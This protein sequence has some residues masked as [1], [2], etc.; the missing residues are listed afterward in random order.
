MMLTRR[1]LYV[2]AVNWL[3]AA[4][5]PAQAPVSL[6][7]DTTSRGHAIPDDFSGLSF[8]RGTENSGNAGVPGYLFSPSNTQLVT[9][10]QNLG[11]RNLRVGGGSVDDEIPVGTGSDGYAGVD[12]LFQF[13]QAA[14]VKVIYSLRLLNPSAQ[15][16]PNL[17]ADNA[18]LAQHIWSSYQSNLENFSI[19]NEP[20]FHSYHT[21]DPLI[22]ETIPGV[23]GSAYP[24][25]L[26][27]W[28][29]FANTVL[30]SVPGAIFS[31]PDTGA[32][33]TLTYTPDASTGVSWTQ[34][35]VHD[36]KSVQNQNNSPLVVDATQHYYV[37]G[38]P[39]STT[40]QQ[41]IDN[42]LSADWVDDTTIGT[43]PAGT[44]G[45]T[46]FTPYPWLYTNNLAPVLSYGLPYRLTESNDYVTGVPGA[47]NAFASALWALD[48]MH[49]WAEHNAAGVNFHNK[50]WIYTD[51]I[52]PDPNPCS[53]VCGNYQTAPKGYG[54]KA[55]D[56]GGHGYVEPVTMENPSGV[57]VTAYAVG[58]ARDLY[59]TIINKTQAA[60][61]TDANV[62]ITPK[63]FR[64][65]S[66][67]SM[68]LGDGQPGNAGLMTASLG[69]AS[70]NNNSRWL[71]QW[72]PLEPNRKGQCT[73][74][75][76]AATAALVKLRAA[77]AYVGPI[78]INQDG[79]LAIFGVGANGDIWSDSQKSASVPNSSLRNWSGWTGLSGSVPS[80][81]GVA[82][83]KNL[84]NTLE[85]FISTVSGDVYHN[86][87]RTPGGAWS[88]WSDLGG[89]GI[90]N[91]VTAVNADG[92]L[93]V[94]GIGANGDIWNN[95]ENAPGVAWSGWSDLNGVNIEPG[96]VIGRDLSGL[97][98]IFGVDGSGAVWHDSQT[99]LG[100]WS[101]WS[102]ADLAGKE[103]NPRLT[104]AGNLD[105][106]LEVFGV[107][108]KGAVWHNPQMTPGGAWNGWSKIPGKRLQPGFVVGQSNDGRLVLFGVSIRAHREWS[109]ITQNVWS[110]SQETAGG[111]F[112]G[113][114][115]NLGGFGIDQLAVSNTLDGRIQ[116][117]GVGRNHDVW[118]DWQLQ[119]G[120]W[121]SGWADFGGTGINLAL[122]SPEQPSR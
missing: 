107:D 1:I 34:Q 60:G 50:Q 65:A 121:W 119:S 103:L 100:G 27:D 94:F 80:A 87:Q 97:L 21:S 86:A 39:G 105:G 12:N 3:W 14:G 45:T 19:G 89:N 77:G 63:G 109:A 110:I 40:A 114:W 70:I 102:S 92:S 2:A 54:L 24:S 41:A 91:L 95:S 30:A 36:E 61:G 52:V 90:R 29:D 28:Q 96:F 56:L 99:S 72:S 118:S 23:P 46:T 74:A 35:F 59:V 42:M 37:G 51:T 111:D 5:A 22:H 6:T 84:D 68:L 18:A 53:P 10:F 106:R 85:V 78:Q 98:E 25:Y 16:I 120:A 38:S 117:F 69:G 26:A 43:Q 116:L 33:S 112:R 58:N 4:T 75:V 76:Q 67:A 44:S 17:K 83:A 71:G 47:S 82:V 15:P 13:A 108:D 88:G 9:L 79:A 57:N 104:V 113:D 66:C 48:Y 101:G 32:Y 64:A 11:I 73:L 49:W 62:T 122:N 115:T 7:I 93:N 55:F 20:D 31:G 8:E 81:G